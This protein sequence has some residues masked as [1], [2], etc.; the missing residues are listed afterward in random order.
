MEKPGVWA[1][2]G[3][4]DT[5]I[6]TWMKNANIFEAVAIT[7]HWTPFLRSYEDRDFD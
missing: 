3:Q 4:P 1:E 2:H 6:D 5:H 7:Y